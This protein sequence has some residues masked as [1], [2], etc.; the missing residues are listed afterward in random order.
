MVKCQKSMPEDL[1]SIQCD[2]NKKAKALAENYQQTGNLENLNEAIRIMEHVVDMAGEYIDPCVLSNLGDMLNIRFE[3]TGSIE[4]LNRSIDAS[5]MAADATPKDHPEHA[6]RL[7]A[8]GGN[9]GSRFE[10]N[11]S[12]DDIDRALNVVDIAVNATSEDHPDRAHRLTNL[13]T[14]L[15]I[16]FRRTG[17]IDD[18][19][20][21]INVVDITVNATSEDHPDR[22]YRLTTLGALLGAR[23]ERT[24]SIDDI[25]RAINVMDIAVNATNTTSEDYPDRAHRLTTLGTLLG[26]RF[27]RTGSIDDINRAINVVDIVVN[28]TSEDYPDRAHRLTILGTLL[29]I[30]FE[31]T[32]SMDDINR[33]INVADIAVNIVPQDYPSRTTCLNALGLWLYERA[34][35]MSSIDDLNRAIDV[36]N[37]AVDATPQNHPDRIF[38]LNNLGALFGQRFN[39]TGSIND[40]QG[41]ID[42]VNMALNAIPQDHPGRT[43]CL[44]NLGKWLFT[45]F[46]QLDSIDDLNRALNLWK[47]AWRCHTAPPS[48]R[49]QMAQVAAMAFHTQSI[50][51]ESFDWEESSLLL[52][53]AVNLLPTVSPRSLKH[54]D[55]QYMLAKFAGLASM[56]AAT[57]LTAGKDA[58]H[59]LQLLELGRGVIA[60]L[61][62]EM[63]GDISDLKQQHPGLA[64]EFTSLR[65]ELDTSVDKMTSP[66]STDSTFPWESQ[67]RRRREADQRFSGLIAHIRAQSGFSNFL[68]PPTAVEFMT[69]AD[70][71]PIIVVNL[72][73]R[74]CDAF[75]IERD[76][77][78]VLPLP[79]LPLSRVEKHA[80]DLRSSRR[81]ASFDATP[82]LEWLWDAICCL[83]ALGFK[84][85][86][87][88]ND[89]PRV[90]WIPTGVLSQFPLHAAGRHAPGSTDTVLDRVMSSYAPSVKALIYGRRHH[91]R[92][93]AGP[94]SDHALLVAMHKTPGL[95]TNGNLPFAATEVK[96]LNNLC[97]SLQLQ[98][99]TPKLRK[100]DVLQHLQ[101]CKIFHFAG[102]GQSHQA[103][104]S[105]SCLLLEDWETNPLTVGDLRDQRLHDNP[106]FLGYLSACSTGANEVDKLVDE[107]IHLVSAFQLAG[108]RHVIGTLWEVSDQHCVD[109][110]R[111]LYETLRG[112]GM[113]DVAVCRGLHRAV[114]AL[115]DGQ[116][117]GGPEGRDAILLGSVPKARGP[118][119]HYW[120][121]YVH[122]GV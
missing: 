7:V 21:A 122:F 115:R 31:R 98:P 8:L 17:S 2:L 60:G 101:T 121:P 69:A 109:V 6:H 77:I 117:E 28:T 14:L 89:W 93:S 44:H 53:E 16:R 40:I 51:K 92:E 76:Q 4:D 36:I 68:L 10:R 105:Q 39:R 45:R 59:A 106:P 64:D 61:L 9:L 99:I 15:G 13:G 11:G 25:N 88:D 52:Q 83:E 66:I 78:R 19:N 90:W 111:V 79:S 108:F 118:T 38:Y 120:I 46:T 30:R 43:I 75:L 42:T 95:S 29:G 54:T 72:D 87:S 49:I 65:D 20:R 110:A 116:M 103:E 37:V 27:K 35:Q 119:N 100:D 55:K 47:E 50:G 102:H 74:R 63:R 85:R 32:G 26:T 82:M 3:R 18:I 23:F 73:E 96:M 22:A 56:A 5:N 94:M 114:R 67:E 41:A 81:A 33:A 58:Y 12:M 1:F 107:G 48:Y 24:G 62:M 84:N 80:Q 104:P 113:T 71:N 57:V 70:P 34:K 86:I 97:P 91:V 112:E